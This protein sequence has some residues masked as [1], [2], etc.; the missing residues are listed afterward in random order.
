[1]FMYHYH[2]H[3]LTLFR[4]VSFWISVDK[5][6]HIPFLVNFIHFLSYLLEFPR[7][8]MQIYLAV[9]SPIALSKHV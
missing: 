7:K 9:T 5:R 3:H 4:A 6:Y 8:K 2:I 1:M